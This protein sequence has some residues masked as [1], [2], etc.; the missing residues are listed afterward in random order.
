MDFL[1]CL[2]MKKDLA[3]QNVETYQEM[4]SHLPIVTLL[5]ATI[6]SLRIKEATE[7]EITLSF[8]MQTRNRDIALIALPTNIFGENLLATFLNPEH[9]IETLLT[10]E[11]ESVRALGMF[12]KALAAEKKDKDDEPPF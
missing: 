3:K 5:N 8:G 4:C 11:K 7:K 2:K 12:L 10:S 6:H 1:E 9:E